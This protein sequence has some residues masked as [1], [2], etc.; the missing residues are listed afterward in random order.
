MN[1]TILIRVFLDTFRQ[2]TH[3]KVSSIRIVISREPKSVIVIESVKSHDRIL[4]VIVKI[5]TLI[6]C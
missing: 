5:V 4:I 1:I 3:F 2:F 6:Y